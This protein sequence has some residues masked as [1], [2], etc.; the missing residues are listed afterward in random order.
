MNLEEKI[1]Q[2]L[3]T[4]PIE[5]HIEDRDELKERI[6]LLYW[7]E[8]ECF[9]HKEFGQY[10]DVGYHITRLIDPA[11]AENNG[12][13]AAPND[14][15]YFVNTIKPLLIKF[16]FSS[17]E[18]EQVQ[19]KYSA[20]TVC[21]KQN[22]IHFYCYREAMND[23]KASVFATSVGGE[24]LRNIVKDVSYEKY[25][26]LCALGKPYIVKITYKLNQLTSTS[27]SAYIKEKLKRVY[28]E[29]IEHC[30]YKPDKLFALSIEGDVSK[31]AISV[32][33]YSNF[34]YVYTNF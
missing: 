24:F 20:C 11:D 34:E 22:K 1:Y 27:F 3:L 30:V 8:D 21:S 18:I 10:E 15:A 13:I 28:F 32:E 14:E 23:S 7:I 26:D 9:W 31:E 4:H 17:E 33:E 19:G 16:S 25:K 6:A 5:S 29:K 2:W 12:L